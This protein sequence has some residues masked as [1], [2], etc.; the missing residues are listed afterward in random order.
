MELEVSILRETC[1]ALSQVNLTKGT[2]KRTCARFR[3]MSARARCSSGM[4]CWLLLPFAESRSALQAGG[5]TSCG[6]FTD[7][8]AQESKRYACAE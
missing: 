5:R 1:T 3:S 7:V 2:D 4:R 8:D 6:A